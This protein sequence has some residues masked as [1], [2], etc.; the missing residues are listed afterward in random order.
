MT[1]H[2]HG[3]GNKLYPKLLTLGGMAVSIIP[4]TQIR[5]KLSWRERIFSW[6]FRPWVSY[7]IEIGSPLLAEGQV[8]RYENTLY[9]TKET[10]QRLKKVEDNEQA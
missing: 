6:P 9:M 4:K 10:F 8:V 7:R 2:H 3:S 5:R 1:E